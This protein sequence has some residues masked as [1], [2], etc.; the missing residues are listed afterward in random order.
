METRVWPQDVIHHVSDFCQAVFPL[1]FRSMYM[2]PRVRLFCMGL[3]LF[4]PHPRDPYQSIHPTNMKQ[5]PKKSCVREL[6]GIRWVKYVEIKESKNVG[7]SLFTQNSAL[8]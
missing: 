3:F 4:F 7:K 8:E 2:F 5:A 6:K 1:S